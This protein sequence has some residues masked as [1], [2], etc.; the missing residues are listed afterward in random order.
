[1]DIRSDTI[2]LRALVN[3]HTFIVTHP[4]EDYADEDLALISTIPALKT[5][6]YD[7][8]GVSD[9]SLQ[10][11]V[12]LNRTLS[13]LKLGDLTN[14]TATG[15]SFLRH[16]VALQSFSVLSL[17][18]DIIGELASCCLATSL[19]IVWNVECE[20][21]PQVQCLL[22]M[23]HLRAIAV[24]RTRGWIKLSGDCKS[25]HFVR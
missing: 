16:M 9:L 12:T 7:S 20:D 1:M 11:L 2:S 15:L 14:V 6:V 17:N 10:R 4:D 21:E 22:D 18:P 24:V 5:L 25:L 3:L 19:C 13:S 8:G 23:P